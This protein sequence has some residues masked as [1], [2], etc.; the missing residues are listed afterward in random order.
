MKRAVFFMVLLYGGFV[1]KAQVASHVKPER[2]LHFS[3]KAENDHA[4]N[5][6]HHLSSRFE[7]LLAAPVSVCRPQNDELPF[8]CRQ[9]AWLAKKLNMPVFIRLG[10]VSYTDFLEQ[11]TTVTDYR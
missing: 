5:A 10:S 8:F 4:A 9:E 11:K 6:V 2:L 1:V 3:L 7:T